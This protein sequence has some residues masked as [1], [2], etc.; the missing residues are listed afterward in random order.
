MAVQKQKLRLQNK[1]RLDQMA[2]VWYQPPR[3]LKKIRFS[4]GSPA[5]KN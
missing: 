3:R 2:A 1:K 4:V 5:G